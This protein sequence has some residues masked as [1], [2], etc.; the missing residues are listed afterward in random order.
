VRKQTKPPFAA[1]PRAAVRRQK[2][3]ADPFGGAAAKPRQ[4][5]VAQTGGLAPWAAGARKP[6][7][8][9]DE[10]AEQAGPASNAT[11]CCGGPRGAAKAAAPK[12]RP[13]ARSSQ[14]KIKPK[15]K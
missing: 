5:P 9:D 12:G 8:D 7:I 11:A 15:G 13:T 6:A 1:N 3:V 4:S 2:S 10:R 14:P